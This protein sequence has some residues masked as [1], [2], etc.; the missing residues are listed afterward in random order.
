MAEEEGLKLE[1]GASG[2]A[3]CPPTD[4]AGSCG[5]K[6]RQVWRGV[7]RWGSEEQDRIYSV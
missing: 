6:C 7:C 4:G 2:R 1:R 5:A 3:R